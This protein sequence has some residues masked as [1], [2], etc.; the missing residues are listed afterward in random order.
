MDVDV[1][2]VVAAGIVV[3]VG[4]PRRLA[5]CRA[6]VGVFP[7]A[8]S[9]SLPSVSLLVLFPEDLDEVEELTLVAFLPFRALPIVSGIIEEA[10]AFLDFFEPFSLP[11]EDVVARS[12]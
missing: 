2:A 8:E 12:E 3:G 7:W 4:T 9:S 10:E 5:R 11:L 1:D 6:L